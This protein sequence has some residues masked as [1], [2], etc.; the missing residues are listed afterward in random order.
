MKQFFTLIL[1]LFCIPAFAQKKIVREYIEWSDVWIPGANKADLPHILLI[2]NSITRGYYKKVEQA[3]KGK[4]YVGRLSNSKCVGDPALLEEIVVVLKNTHFDIIHFN[5][6]LHGFDYTEE[7]YDKNFPKL[8]KVIRKYAPKA[9]LIWA[10][11]TPVRAGEKMKEFAPITKRLKKR[12]EIALKYINQKGIKV[13]DLW[14]VVVD[15]PEYYEGGD[16]IH[17]ADIGYS[18]LAKQVSQIISCEL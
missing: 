1:L 13:N 8:I 17:P 9:K 11:T 12:N 4:A 14:N 16:G 7:E 15:H 3:L 10:T 2:G 6:G 5:N 18:A